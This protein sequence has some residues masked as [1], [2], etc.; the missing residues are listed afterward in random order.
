M[1][2]IKDNVDLKELEKYGFKL[3]PEKAYYYIS[4]EDFELFIWLPS[5]NDYKSRHIYIEPKRYSTILFKL[6]VVYLMI[7]DG[8]VEVS[9][10]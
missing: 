7:L 4:Y 3:E 8:I 10:E 6:D 9:N 1:L 5:G 2:K